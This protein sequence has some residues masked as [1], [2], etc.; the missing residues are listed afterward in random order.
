MRP[1]F[2]LLCLV[3]GTAACGSVQFTRTAGVP[4]YKALSAAA[5][6]T[7]A[8]STD[9][10]PQ[11]VVVV[12]TLRSESKTEDPAPVEAEMRK[13]A[14][15]Y[16]C[17]AVAGLTAEI[18]EKKTFKSV[19][20]LGQ[21]GKPTTTRQE[22]VTRTWKW[23]AQCVRTAAL[24]G[25]PNAPEPPPAPTDE[26]ASPTPGDGGEAPAGKDSAYT[27]VAR[28]LAQRLDRYA[29]GMLRPWKD[30]LRAERPEPMDTIEALS[31]LMI[32]VTG[33]TGL[34]R[35]TVPAQWYGCAEDPTSDQ[36]QK[37]MMATRKL[38]KLD[39]FQSQ[40]A[41]V[42]RGQAGPWLKKNVKRVMEY[43]DTYVPDEP[44]LSGC[45]A[46]PFYQTNLL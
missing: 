22:V 6:V 4:R 18:D 40:V 34:W 41:G 2:L 1:I 3:L 35:K 16:G 28:E 39:A 15:R 36:C 9:A 27:P 33:P 26:V 30:R 17:D 29:D 20:V 13:H 31:D 12:G 43:L 14:S 5:Q 32:Q 21:D 8:P 24:G 23:S 10:L 45:Q 11:P 25:D 46:T 7:V 37:L 38:E 42:S 44:S 19:Q